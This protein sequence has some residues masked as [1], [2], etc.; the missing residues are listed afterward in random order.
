VSH[1]KF[2]IFDTPGSNSASNLN[3]SKVLENALE[4][5]SNG[6]PVWMSQYET[7]DSQDNAAL[8]D[9]ILQIKALDERF[10]MIIMNKADVSD[11]PENGFTSDEAREIM[12]FNAVEK[13]YSSGIYF[14]SSIMGLGAKKDGELVDKHYRKIFRSQKNMYIDEN[15]EDYVTLY[16]YNIMPE[17]MKKSLMML[18]EQCSDKVFAN[19]GLYG[20]EASMEIFAGK[21]AAYNKCQMVYMFLNSVIDET[22]KRIDG[23]TKFLE[24]NRKLRETELEISK[25]NLLNQLAKEMQKTVS[26]LLYATTDSLK[27]YINKNLTFEYPVGELEK[28]EC[29]LRKQ[30]AS[31]ANIEL[32]QQNLEEDR[33]NMWSHFKNNGQEILQGHFD[34]LRKMA[35]DLANDHKEVRESRESKWNTEREIDKITSDMIMKNVVEK[36]RDEISLS[37]DS[38]NSLLKDTWYENAQKLRCRLIEIITGTEVLTELQKQNLS[39]III[40][41][42]SLSF[43]DGS[44][45]RFSKKKFLRGMLFGLRVNDSEKI[46]LRLLSNRYNKWIKDTVGEIADEVNK[47]CFDGFE[48]WRTGLK[49]AIE[50]NITEL[51]PNLRNMADL[52]KEET[53]KILELS[54]NRRKIGEALDDIKDLMSWTNAE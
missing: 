34:Y 6:I 9:K 3:H 43:D 21:Y 46:N 22:N 44:E 54:T 1:N 4:S 47:S 40:N 16:K 5:F 14:L 41:Y 52:I 33:N 26:D 31:E 28:L 32:H 13:M 39:S 23:K 17:T 38:L 29:K 49:A 37:I 20:V 36:Y 7:V 2:V 45:K 30:N 48:E 19:S 25:K 12:E 15:D 35:D 18:S 8:C 50:A 24:D 10:T 53:E 27:S 11:L 42:E 51:N